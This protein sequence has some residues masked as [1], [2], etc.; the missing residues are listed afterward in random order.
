MAR[1]QSL[2][3]ELAEFRGVLVLGRALLVV[4]ERVVEQLDKVGLKVSLSKRERF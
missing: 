1:T 4:G 3:E 2:V